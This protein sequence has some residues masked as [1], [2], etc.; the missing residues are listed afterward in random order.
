MMRQCLYTDDINCAIEWSG[1]SINSTFTNDF[2]RA[3]PVAYS[4]LRIWRQQTAPLS[5]KCT[6]SPSSARSILIKS[7]MLESESFFD[8]STHDH[9]AL[10]P[11]TYITC[12]FHSEE[13]PSFP[14]L[15]Q[16]FP[17]PFL[18]PEPFPSLGNFPALGKC[19]GKILGRS[20]DPSSEHAWAL[21]MLCEHIICVQYRSRCLFA[22]FQ[23]TNENWE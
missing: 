2:T 16:G 15:S 3:R 8:L 5:S 10:H 17:M 12:M 6:G 7:V 23:F 11:I 9:D 18:F 20:P 4:L 13:Q 21:Q 14:G 19:P 22:L 1:T